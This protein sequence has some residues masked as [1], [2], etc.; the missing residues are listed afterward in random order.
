M[1]FKGHQKIAGGRNTYENIGKYLFWKRL[2]VKT[3]QILKEEHAFVVE[4]F[5]KR[6]SCIPVKTEFRQRFNR[7]TF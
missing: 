5:F 3:S 2:K 7:N 4:N 6:K 1:R